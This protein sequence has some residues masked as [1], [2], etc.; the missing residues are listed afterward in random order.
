MIETYQEDHCPIFSSKTC[1]MDKSLPA[2]YE[3][4]LAGVISDKH[5][6]E[7]ILHFCNL[8]TMGV[9]SAAKQARFCRPNLANNYV[10]KRTQI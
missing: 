8:Q 3:P 9:V 6:T 2:A 7:A 4:W 10:D 1:D 5:G